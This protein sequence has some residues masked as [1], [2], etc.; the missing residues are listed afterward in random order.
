MPQTFDPMTDPRIVPCD[1]CQA[2]GRIYRGQYEDERD[3]GECP[4]CEGTGSEIIEAEP[5]EMED[6]P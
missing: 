1:Y 3:C 4:V 6:L 5:I 2:E